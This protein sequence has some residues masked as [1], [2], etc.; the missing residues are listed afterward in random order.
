MNTKATHMQ[1]I[2]D[3]FHASQIYKKITLKL[4]SEKKEEKEWVHPNNCPLYVYATHRSFSMKSKHKII[5]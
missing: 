2:C 5:E 4:W 1:R 3:I